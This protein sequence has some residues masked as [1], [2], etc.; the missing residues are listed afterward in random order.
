MPTIQI[1]DDDAAIRRSL[2]LHYEEQGHRVVTADTAERG[3]AQVLESDIDLVITDV[4][5]PGEGGFWLLDKLRQDRP[6]TPVIITTAYHDM[7]TTVQAMQGG[8]IDY[9]LKP[10][11]ISELDAVVQRGLAE[12]LRDLGKTGL[13]LDR[14]AKNRSL[15]IGQSR[16][17]KDVLKQIALVA[18]S[19]LNV[20]LQGESGTGK[21]LAA[22]AIHQSGQNADQPFLAVNC[23]A[24]VETLLE[25]EMFG[26]ERGA[27]TGAVKAHKGK[28]E[29]AGSGTLFLDEI[30]ELSPSMQSKLLRLLE[31]REY[32]PVG[33]AAIKTCH[34]RFIAASNLDLAD[35]VQQ[36]K[37]REDLY[38]R[39]NVVAIE[40][41]PL[42]KR[43]EDIPQLTEHLVA[44][45]NRDLNRSVRGVAT[46]ALACL[47]SHDWPGNVRELDNVLMKAAVMSRGPVLSCSDLPTQIQGACEI[48]GSADC[49]KVEYCPS[50]SLGS[51]DAGKVASAGHPAPLGSL[52]DLERD[53]IARVLEST[54]WH[55]GRAC[56]VLGISRPKLDRRIK[57]FGLDPG[58]A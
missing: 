22:R 53:H 13:D 34:A 33:S 40:M 5:M 43:I 46:S 58:Q 45:I 25:S 44:R 57:E 29:L 3:L 51:A 30:G 37:F 17:M 56:E 6:D 19:P 27:F 26:H 41:P 8:A 35:L 39:L 48:D 28:V 15:I 54:D 55:K 42:R 20:L 49:P 50:H 36:G 7:E 38:Y 32:S 52:R 14:A 1:T 16:A 24:L 11:D 10:I 4:R 18:Q 31:A 21:E 2:Q 12:P 23:A 47:Q 9:V